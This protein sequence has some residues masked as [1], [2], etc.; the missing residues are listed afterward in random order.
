MHLLN[1]ERH[2]LGLFI[3]LARFR[4]PGSA[5]PKHLGPGGP[6]PLST[7]VRFHAP[8]PQLT[9]QKGFRHQGDPL[10]TYV[11]YGR[12]LFTPKNTTSER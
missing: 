6:P 1:T 12:A 11:T 7:C 2:C 9:T 8:I 4:A 5:P 3:G 10:G